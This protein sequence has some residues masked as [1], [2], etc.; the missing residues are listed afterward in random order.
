MSVSTF[1]LYLIAAIK[2]DKGFSAPMAAALV[3]V[4]MAPFTLVFMGP[5]NGEM[6]HLQAA[7]MVSGQLLHS[8]T[9]HVVF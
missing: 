2:T 3:A 8:N 5:L 9:H 7:S 6:F 4:T 1:I